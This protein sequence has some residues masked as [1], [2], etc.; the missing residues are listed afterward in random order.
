MQYL[1]LV[2]YLALYIITRKNKENY[3]SLFFPFETQLLMMM[4]TVVVLLLL[5]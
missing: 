1:Y 3:P 2:S 4:I 5:A